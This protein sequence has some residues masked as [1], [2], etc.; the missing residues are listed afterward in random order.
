MTRFRRQM[1]ATAAALGVAAIAVASASA[2]ANRD[3]D[4]AFGRLPDAGHHARAR[5]APCGSRTSAP[6]RSG[7]SP[8]GSPASFSLP[9]PRSPCHERPVR[10]HDR[11]G[12]QPLV[13]GVQRD[14][15]PARP[16][17]AASPASR[18]SASPTAPNLKGITTGARRQALVP[19]GRGRHAAVDHDR[20]RRGRGDRL[21]AAGSTA[22]TGSR[23]GPAGDPNV[24]FTTDNGVVGK[25]EHVRRPGCARPRSASTPTGSPSGPTGTSGSPPRRRQQGEPRRRGRAV[26]LRLRRSRAAT[27]AASPTGPDGALWF[28]EYATELGRPHHDGRPGEQHPA[29]RLRAPRRHRGRTRTAPLWVTCFGSAGASSASPRA[30]ASRRPR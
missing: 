10:H 28:A 21:G 19:R 18:R 29:E 7:A 3:H 5:T 16:G 20:R 8:A 22:R 6:S 14:D 30:R 1:V 17:R 15:R 23:A 27:P 24:Y 4:P 12:R 9:R 26:V 2:A 25:H 11:P 13:H